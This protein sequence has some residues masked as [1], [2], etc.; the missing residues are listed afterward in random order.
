MDKELTRAQLEIVV[1][2]ANGLRYEEIAELTHRSE[3][4]VKLILSTARKRAGAK[5]TTHLVSMVIATGLLEWQPDLHQRQL[6]G[7]I[8]DRG[9]GP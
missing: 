1:H 2:V 4:T 9:S 5:T 7:N 6:N 8:D 3:S